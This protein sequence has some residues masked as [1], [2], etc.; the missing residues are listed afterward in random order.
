VRQSYGYG[1]WAQG[2]TPAV[3]K[4]FPAA[5]LIRDRGVKEARPRHQAN[6]GEVLLKTD[7]RWADFHNAREIGGFS[8]AWGPYGFQSGVTQ[9]DVSKSE[10]R[11]LGLAVD[12]N[13]LPAKPAKIT[14]GTEASTKK[15][16]PDIKKKLLEELRG[17]P[18]AKDPARAGRDAAAD[19]RRIMLQRGLADAEARGDTGKAGKYQKAIADLPDTAQGFKV[20]EDGD[21]IILNEGISQRLSKLGKTGED[22][23][24]EQDLAIA[25]KIF[26][27]VDRKSAEP[28]TRPDPQKGVARARQLFADELTL[29][30]EERKI[31]K[32]PHEILLV[33]DAAGRLKKSVLGTP[34]NVSIPD[35]INSGYM[36]SHNHPSGRGPSDSDIKAVL[37]RPGTA[38]RIVAMNEAGNVEIFEMRSNESLPAAVI[39]AIADIYKNEAAKAGDSHAARRSA[40]ALIVEAFGDMISIKT[41]IL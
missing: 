16:D 27:T 18:K 23:T 17:G 39:D 30:P 31:L 26:E 38:L 22:S 8:V 7:P 3:R 12:N 9:T 19:V 35:N 4:A 40:L 37:S 34:S 10:A 32:S 15:M 24:P 25:R 14:D 5:R 36:L 1:Q 41:A 29:T 33:H 20:I 28:Q 13:P 2:M 6:L 21:R 11:Q